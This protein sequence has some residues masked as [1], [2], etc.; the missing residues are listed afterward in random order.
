M[1]TTPILLDWT[2]AQLDE[3]RAIAWA[4]WLQYGASMRRIMSIA[5]DD[6]TSC[7]VAVRPKV[8]VLEPDAYFPPGS[9][10]DDCRSVPGFCWRNG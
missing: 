7:A 8:E 1:L 9:F 10:V 2:P 5:W 3:V 6:A 4:A